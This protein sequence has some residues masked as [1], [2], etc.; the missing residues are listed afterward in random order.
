MNFFR[1]FC[2]RIRFCDRDQMSCGQDYLFPVFLQKA[3]GSPSFEFEIDSS[4]QN[5]IQVHCWT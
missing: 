3:K 4:I 2:G 5:A 1:S